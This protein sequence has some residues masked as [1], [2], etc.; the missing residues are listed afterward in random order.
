MNITVAGM[1]RMGQ[2]LAKRLLDAGHQVTIW[3]RTT[4]R[5][6][7]LLEAGAT[8]EAELADAVKDASLVITILANDDAVRSVALDEG[9]LRHLLA[10]DA[11]YVDAS[12][13]SPELSVDLENAFSRFAAM[14]IL[15]APNAVATGQATYVLA[16]ADDA[17]GA[18]APIMDDLSD[19]VIRY[20]SVELAAATKLTVNLLLLDSLVALSEAF[21]VGRAGGLSDDQLRDLLADHPMVPKGLAN[22]FEGVLTGDQEP[23]WTAD[24]GAKDVGLAVTL[25][26]TADRDLPMTSAARDQYLRAA[27]QAGDAAAV[28]IAAVTNLYRN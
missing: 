27:E 18:V 22:R 12:T 7:E 4:G 14:P 9:G 5:A 1:G 19:K 13:V 24:L 10:D 28:D 11:T 16:G 6:P 20:D 2:A 21:A 3:N 15:G 26:A 17:T 8:E 23:W 25:A